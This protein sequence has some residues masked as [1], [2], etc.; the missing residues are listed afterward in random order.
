LFFI[1]NG[2]GNLDTSSTTMHNYLLPLMLETLIG[3]HTSV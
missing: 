1:K 3:L 2:N